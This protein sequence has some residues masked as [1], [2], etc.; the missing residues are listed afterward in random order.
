[1]NVNELSLNQMKMEL[2]ETAGIA[3]RLADGPGDIS[4]E[5]RTHP[6]QRAGL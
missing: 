1:M 6:E 5:C 3:A 4:A 2:N